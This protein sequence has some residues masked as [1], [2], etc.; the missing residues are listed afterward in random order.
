[1]NFSE[2]SKGISTIIGVILIVGVIV[3]LSSLAAVVVFEIGGSTSET[4]EPSLQVEKQGDE[5]IVNVL[6]NSD[7]EYIMIEGPSDN[8]KI[9]SNP[10]AGSSVSI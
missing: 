7:A 10:V 1:M 5:V 3:A 2:Y 8:Q 6:R 4:P 9:I